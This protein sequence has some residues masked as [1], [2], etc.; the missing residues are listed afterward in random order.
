MRKIE[1]SRATAAMNRAPG[2]VMQDRM[3]AVLLGLGQG[4]CRDEAALL[5]DGVGLLR[6]TE[7]DG[8]V[9]MRSR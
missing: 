6:G 5:A 1:G 4:G 2:G 9:E 8:R 3:W 7:R